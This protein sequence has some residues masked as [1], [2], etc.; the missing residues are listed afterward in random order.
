MD[1]LRQTT[2]APNPSTLSV[3]DELF[4]L[5]ADI[6]PIFSSQHLAFVL[7][8]SLSSPY[9]ESI[10][11]F[12]FF[13]CQG[14]L[15][16]TVSSNAEDKKN[17]FY[18][19]CLSTFC[20]VVSLAAF[21]DERRY[22]LRKPAGWTSI[23]RSYGLDTRAQRGLRKW[24]QSPSSAV[25]TQGTRILTPKLHST[26][27]HC[28]TLAKSGG[29]LS[30]KIKLPAILPTGRS[31]LSRPR[32]RFSCAFMSRLANGSLWLSASRRDLQRALNL[33]ELNS[34]IF[35]LS[36][37]LLTIFFC[38]NCNS[39]TFRL[40]HRSWSECE[41]GTSLAAFL[42]LLLPEIP[43]CVVYEVRYFVV[44]QIASQSGQVP[45]ATTGTSANFLKNLAGPSLGK[46]RVSYSQNCCN[47]HLSGSWSK[48]WPLPR[49]TSKRCM[50][51]SAR[52]N[53]S[54]LRST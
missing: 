43:T 50:C 10:S 23:S 32:A 24:V 9:C 54:I 28:F 22:F 26:S 13:F 17:P 34:V 7:P 29:C 1:L 48:L 47:C 15:F 5:L 52:W 53:D 16:L 40:Q 46:T 51:H 20:P 49:T 6:V 19:L 35:T 44:L 41:H 30:S 3:L 45:R 2:L 42:L 37:Q 12:T 38:S 31:K 4:A 27:A 33:L 14:S 8:K 18:T 36:F 11:L 21:C 25:K 39:C